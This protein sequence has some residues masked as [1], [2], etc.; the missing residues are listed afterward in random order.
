M[1]RSFNVFKTHTTYSLFSVVIAMVALSACDG[2]PSSG[3]QETSMRALQIEVLSSR[4]DMV[5]G[6]DALIEV[7]AAADT[8]LSDLA[9]FLNGKN[10]TDQLSTY[11]EGGIYRGLINGLTVGENRLQVVK[12]VS[13]DAPAELVLNNYPITGP[14]ISGPHLNPYE[15]R[16]EDAGLGPALD[17]N[18]SAT[19]KIEYFY[20][21]NDGEFKPMPAE[22]PSDIATT[23]TNQ[24]L[25]VP[26]IVRVDSGTINRTIYR[27][28]ILDDGKLKDQEQDTEAWRPTRIWNSRLGVS[29]GGGAG[30]NYNQGVNQATSVLNHTF[31]SRGF[32]FMIS[33]E[34][35]NRQ[36]ANA[37]L[38]GET[39]MMLKEYFIEN[40]GLPV[41]TVGNGGSGGAIQQLLITQ[42]F[43]GLLDGIRPSLAY[44]DSTLHTADCGS[45]QNYWAKNEK[46]VWTDEKK[47]AVS[48]FSGG[49]CRAWERSFVPVLRATNVRGCGLKDESLVYH[50]ETNPTGAR[51]TIQE[52]RANFYGR[53]A[54]THYARKPQDNIGLQYGLAALNNGVISVDEFLH[55][56]ANIGGNDLDGEF[57]DQRSVGDPIAIRAAYYYGFIDSGA[58]GLA[59]VPIL[60]YRD[61]RDPLGDIHDR[62]RD[63]TIRARLEKANGRSDNQVIWLG[64]YRQRGTTP[65]V[66]IAALSL[67]VMTKW[68]NNMI[69]DPAPLS[70]DKVVKNKPTEAVDTC[71]NEDYSQKIVEPASFDG[72]TQCNAL[73][74]VHS[75]PRL[76]AGAPLANDIM[77]CQLKPIDDKD[78]AVEFSSDQKQELAK[79]FPEGVC[80]FSK[81]GVEQVALGVGWPQ[82]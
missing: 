78:Y 64:P 46:G 81:P 73:Y 19:K 25:T 10:I 49:T 14:I 70:T 47:E 75:E 80:D 6:G 44:P 54:D 60:H 21:S 72:D 27:I 51:C 4:P 13:E 34:L 56:N 7:R 71:W 41:W 28:A 67:D 18:C 53:H 38:Q 48:G 52:M 39:L 37:I 62:H 17:E 29:F 12:A 23:T 20:R 76:V 8:S 3:D 69:A 16:T 50:P 1:F 22:T 26:Y 30:T 36:H 9:L 82:K 5:T 68:L 11:D 45:L 33:S 65:A 57:V 59:N 55:L 40:Y 66:D 35:V 58:G 79:I 32:A 15:C 63:F 42:L 77:K 74:P 43:P 24:G 61:Y 31:L 2:S